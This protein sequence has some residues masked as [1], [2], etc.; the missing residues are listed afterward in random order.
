MF[1][2]FFIRLLSWILKVFKFEIYINHMLDEQGD[3]AIMQINNN[4]C[5]EILIKKGKS[6]IILVKSTFFLFR[7]N[8][9]VFLI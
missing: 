1:N 4:K 5:I 9:Q 3:N 2:I 6:L 8:E 7:G